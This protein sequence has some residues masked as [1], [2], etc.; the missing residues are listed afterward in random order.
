VSAE[1]MPASSR[2]SGETPAAALR[3]F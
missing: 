2:R 1:H 3:G